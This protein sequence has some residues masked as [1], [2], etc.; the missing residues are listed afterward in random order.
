M[1]LPG[2]LYFM[3]PDSMSSILEEDKDMKV[4]PATK[5][6][7][8]IGPESR[9]A[10]TLEQLLHAGMVIARFDFSFG[11]RE[12]HQK[13]LDNLKA[14]QAKT[15]KLCAVALDTM[16]PEIVVVN[17]PAGPINLEAGQQ[18]VLTTDRTQ[19]ASS[20]VLPISHP[21]LAALQ[22]GSS[23]FVGQYLFTGSENSS[24]YL[25]V[26]QING[27]SAVCAIN[28]SCSLEGIQLTVHISNMKYEGPILSADD[29]TNITTW[30]KANNVDFLSLSFCRSAQDVADCRQL[31]DG[32]G[33]SSTQIIAKLEDAEGLANYREIIDVA[34][35]IVFSRGNLGICLDA[36]KMF[37]AQKALLRECNL[38]GKP[39]YVTRVVDT[40]TEAPRPT[41][42]EATDVA[43]LVLDGADGILL[44]SETFRGKF[45]VEAV[46]TVLAICKQAEACF[47]SHC[48]YQSVMNH[49]GAYSLHPN[50]SKHEA[51]ASSAVRAAGKLQASLIV[52]F[53]VTGRTP[54]IVAKY[55]PSQP[56]LTVVVPRLTSDGLK[57]TYTGDSKARQCLQ[58]RGVLPICGD[59]TIGSPDGAILA[60]AFQ[61]ASSANMV[62]AGD[63]V[64]VI[65]CPRETAF[66]CFSEAGVVKT[67]TMGEAGHEEVFQGGN[68]YGGVRP[69]QIGSVENL[70]AM[71]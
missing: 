5:M 69:D 50:L 58:Y 70:A 10:D 39:V 52:V 55:R 16:G 11:D 20:T 19:Q 14:A 61:Y 60:Q 23:I 42:A 59:P 66:S 45:P 12:Y 35:A 46:R 38:A 7:A 44:G 63:K 67:F 36:E 13:S 31:L 8:T 3:A 43:N 32:C 68:F 2:S 64:V 26:Q 24:A 9:D 25:T 37:L 4:L 62:K 33:L 57:W 18:L 21:S 6:A 40:M 1:A 71:S 15:R 49:F 53:T 30:G 29:V 65:Q 28:N 22:P 48:Y 47:D 54:R 56:I 17:R 41:R 27:N 51:L 34:D